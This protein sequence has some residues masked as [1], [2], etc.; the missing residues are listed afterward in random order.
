[1][2]ILTYT[3]EH[4]YVLVEEQN[5]ESKYETKDTYS[6]ALVPY[7][8]SYFCISSS[9]EYADKLCRRRETKIES[10]RVRNNRN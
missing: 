3:W 2:V 4:M 10:R 6:D 1:M 7:S 8:L 9:T 5:E